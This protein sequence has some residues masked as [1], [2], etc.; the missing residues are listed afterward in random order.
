MPKNSGGQ[1]YEK[2][3]DE[4]HYTVYNDISFSLQ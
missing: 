1:F 2:Y 3:F 4:L